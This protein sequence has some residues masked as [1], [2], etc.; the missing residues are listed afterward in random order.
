[1]SNPAEPYEFLSST[2]AAD[3][4]RC[5]FQ[6]PQQLTVSRQVGS[7]WPNAGNSFWVTHATGSWHLFTWSPIGYHVPDDVDI[8]ELCRACMN[9]GTRAMHVVPEHIV[10]NFRLE[11]LS[12]DGEARVYQVMGLRE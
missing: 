6:T 3:D 11:R 4:I 8:A 9:H 12:D 5:H 1:M 7:I 10:E 2:L